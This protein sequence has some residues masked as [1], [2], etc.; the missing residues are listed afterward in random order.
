MLIGFIRKSKMIDWIKRRFDQEGFSIVMWVVIAA[1]G[2]YVLMRPTNKQVNKSDFNGATIGTVDQRTV[3]ES[4]RHLIPF[5][6]AFGGVNSNQDSRAEVGV[7]I[8]VR[9]EF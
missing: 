1:I 7:R 6:E 4:R 9:F 5:A 2:A 8:G 3:S